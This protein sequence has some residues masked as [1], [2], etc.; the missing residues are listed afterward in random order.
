MYKHFEFMN[1]YNFEHFLVNILEIL[2]FKV[3]IM[4]LER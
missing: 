4:E 2:I 3:L 1:A